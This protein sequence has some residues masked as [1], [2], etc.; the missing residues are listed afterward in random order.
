[1]LKLLLVL[2]TSVDSSLASRIL[3]ISVSDG[4]VELLYLQ[5]S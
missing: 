2:G 4:E 3:Q 1:M 5:S